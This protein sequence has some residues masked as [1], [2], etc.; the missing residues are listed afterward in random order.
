[1]MESGPFRVAIVI[2]DQLVEFLGFD[3]LDG[4]T[5]DADLVSSWAIFLCWDCRWCPCRLD[6]A[7]AML[8]MVRFE[9]F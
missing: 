1:M 8:A 6:G 7:L 9:V 2:M 4:G 5:K 3:A